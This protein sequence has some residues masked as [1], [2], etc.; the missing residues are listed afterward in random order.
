MPTQEHKEHIPKADGRVS[1]WVGVISHFLS[2][3]DPNQPPPTG[4]LEKVLLQ[5]YCP[6]P[7]RRGGA[8]GALQMC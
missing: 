2:P 7:Q 4:K 1:G 3:S 6:G 8:H 5:D